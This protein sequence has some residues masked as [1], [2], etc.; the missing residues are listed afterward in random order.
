MQ[1]INVPGVGQ[2]N[3]PDD[4]SHENIVAA[5]ENDILPKAT[6]APQKESNV[7]DKVGRANDVG[8]AVAGWVGKN[9]YTG[10][11]RGLVDAGQ[12][13]KQLGMRAGELV[14]LLPKGGADAYTKQTDAERAAFDA[15]NP[16]QNF[17]GLQTGRLAGSTLPFMAMPG[18]V[19]GS[20]I[21]R[22]GTGLLSGMATGAAQYV[23]EGNSRI[24]NTALG[25]LLGLSAP[26]ATAAIAKGANAIKGGTEAPVQKAVIEAGEKAGVPVFAADVSNNPAIRGL[27]TALEDIP[28][29]GMRGKRNEQML[30]AQNAAG[31][32]TGQLSDEM[33]STPFGGRTGMKVIEKAAQGSGVRAKG[34]Q[35]LLT[36]IK[37]AGDDWNRIAQTSQNTQL[38]RAKLLADKKYEKLSQAADRYGPVDTDNIISAV[39]GMI[40]KEDSAVLKNKDLLK[41]LNEIKDGLFEKQPAQEASKILNQF[42]EPVTQATS[43][44]TAPRGLN[45]TELRDFRS[46]LSDRISDYFKGSNLAIGKKGVGLLQSL[47]MQTDKTLNKFATENGP[48]LKTLWQNADNFYQS[49]VA[50]AKDRLL[51]QSLKN[52]DPDTIYSKWI[53]QGDKKDRATRFYKSLDAKGR[54]AVRYGMVNK[55]YQA[56]LKDTGE[57]MFSPGRMAAELEK[58]KGARGVLFN[59]A[60]KAEID[61]FTNLMRHIDR[62]Y[63]A[64]N[65]PDTGVKTIPYIVAALAGGATMMAPGATAAAAAATGG[66]KLLMTTNA[67]RRL[68][69]AS[70]RL[71]AGSPQM[72]KVAD[73][74]TR[75]LERGAVVGGVNALSPSPEQ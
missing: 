73:N 63:Q 1:T 51:A 4:M 23:P 18:G 59:G 24:F 66:L 74:I 43:A 49:A 35:A 38:F 3:F 45:Y 50:P 54:A 27:S 47:K 9:A 72:Q 25:G 5:I 6:A 17:L 37:N 8:K 55:A 19:A 34:A 20:V 33:L 67:G 16:A 26:V 61:G 53:M 40:K 48:E 39:N 71:K 70:S 15:E 56:A 30:A 52:A 11:K 60:D 29:I 46:D 10:L 41:T 32:L 62:S 64:I 75:F 7:L 58:V 2:I 36:E 14:N 13:I 22:A 31:N 21:K 65:K 28:I 68:L 44:S 57:G 42:G 12:G 69:L